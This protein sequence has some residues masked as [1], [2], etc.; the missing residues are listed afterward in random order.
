MSLALDVSHRFGA[1]TLEASFTAEGGVTALFGPSGSGKT[2]LVR[3]VAGL[4]RPDRGRLT[5]DGRLLVDTERR[6]FVPPH[7]RRVGYVF[8]EPR[9]FPHVSVRRNLTFGRSLA[10]RSEP[11]P[12]MD[13]IVELLGIGHLLA[14]RPASLS[15]GE[16]SRV[17]IGRALLAS[18]RL[19]LL[20]EPLANLDEARR[21]EILP[22]L[23]RLR[24]VAKV[25]ILFVSHA[26]GEVARLANNVVL[27]EQGRVVSVGPAAVALR[28]PG[29]AAEAGALIEA[30]VA[31]HDAE[32]GLAT[33]ATGAGRLR[34]PYPPL[35]AGISVRVHIA[36]RDVM[37][38]T[39]RPVGISA[40]NVL[41]GRVLGVREADGASVTVEV[42]CGSETLAARIT[43]FSAAELALDPGR[44]VFAIIKGVA[45]EAGA[46]L[47]TPTPVRN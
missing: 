37:L 6:V 39:E 13:G 17:A 38:A 40:L 14:R 7:R 22:Y 15:G 43:R 1:F 33:L 8:Q 5:V 28:G 41:E 19:L 10:P 47:G 26:V 45:I 2:S 9:L 20:D 32:F 34:V 30:K 31:A 36:A 44:R 4:L 42:A 18:P 29:L 16:R 12:D 3:I 27:L 24:D 35:A 23:E 25:P 46:P 11:K 21:A